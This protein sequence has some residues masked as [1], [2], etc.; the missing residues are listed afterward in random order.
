MRQDVACDHAD[1]YRASAKIVMRG[2]E[3]GKKSKPRACQYRIWSERL[4]G[5]HFIPQLQHCGD[6]IF[7]RPYFNA[8][9]FSRFVLR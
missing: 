7:K 3:G 1:A 6:A 2:E 4:S 8:Y 9:E 5:E